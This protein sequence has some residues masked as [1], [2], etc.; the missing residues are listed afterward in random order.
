MDLTVLGPVV[1][2]LQTGQDG[3]S[4]LKLGG[5]KNYQSEL[6]PCLPPNSFVMVKY[7][8]F[9]LKHYIVFVKK[10]PPTGQITFWDDTSKM[11]KIKML[12]A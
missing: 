11:A 8:T 4:T 12:L 6:F 3:L 5:V 1:F 2:L 9:H 7:K 10:M